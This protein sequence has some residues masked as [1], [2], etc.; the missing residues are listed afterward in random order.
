MAQKDLIIGGF[1][2]YNYNQLKPWVE[3]IDECGFTGDKVM[4]VGKCS[5]ETIGELIK[6]KFIIVPLLDINAP[7]HVARFLSIYDYLKT[8]YLRYR[9]V[10]TTDVKDVYF[11][12]NPS[13]WLKNNL[14]SSKLVAGSE[15]I[16]YKD[17]PWGNENLMQTYG[18]YVHE[19]F[20]N[21]KI[22]NVGT[23]GGDAEYVKDMIFNIFFNAVNR[24]IPI[25]DQAVYNVLLQTQPFFDVTMFADQSD[26]WA[27]QAGTTVDPSKIESFRSQLTEAEPT[28]KD[29]TVYTSLG[30]PFCIVHQYD[31]VPEWKKYV[32]EKYKQIDESE[33]FIYRT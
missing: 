13:V 2:G 27:C 29:G 31:R 22:Y 19:L 33:L 24:P 17:E 12:T 14:K 9:Y 15:G 21:N 32:Q 16:R 6:Q 11:Q 30:Q 8:H 7:I 23:I 5:Q 28:F 4:I 18:S 25:V 1:T 3:S 10:I 20:K 26:G